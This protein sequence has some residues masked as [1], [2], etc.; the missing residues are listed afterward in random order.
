MQKRQLLASPDL[1]E[2]TPETAYYPN[3]EANLCVPHRDPM[4]K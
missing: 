4:M 2:V 1:D 3:F